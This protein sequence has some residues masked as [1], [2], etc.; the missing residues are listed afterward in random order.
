MNAEMRA[1]RTNLER[2]LFAVALIFVCVGVCA[3]AAPPAY[4]N[5]QTRVTLEASN[6]AHWP[7]RV[8]LHEHLPSNQVM[9][10]GSLYAMV[11]RTNTPERGPYRLVRTTLT[12][13][14]VSRGPLFTVP[15]IAF[16][17]GRLWISG[18]EG[19]LPE[20]IEINPATLRAIRTIHFAQGYGAFPYVEI[21]DGPSGSV[22]L[23]SDQTLLRMSA[24]TGKTLAR[25]SV[26][27]GFIVA[28]IATDPSRTHLYVSLAG[29]VKGGTTGGALIEDDA[30]TGRQIATASSRL[31][32]G[33]VAGSGVTAVTGGVWASFR[34]GMLGLT[35]HFRQRDLASVEPPGPKIAASP[36]NGLFHWPMSASLL[37]GDGALWLTNESGVLACL[38]PVT[39]KA[40]ARERISPQEVLDLLAVDPTGR[41]LIAIDNATTIIEIAAPQRCWS[42]T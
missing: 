24:A 34:T 36:A 27:T 26:P 40:R 5:A 9:S 32:S 20:A 6:V 33:S 16:V 31:L 41:Y 18:P 8:L 28:N 23:G 29:A 35:L 13:D 25:T 3:S 39:G 2:C 22:W 7:E 30:A 4:A 1:R 11:S 19:G 10:G 17:S 15:N 38:D 21:T 12:T 14:R 37:Y 42:G